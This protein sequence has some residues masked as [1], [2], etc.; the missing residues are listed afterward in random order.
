MRRAALA[1][2]LSLGSGALA[3]HAL[4]DNPQ[5]RTSAHDQTLAR[6]AV[7]QLSDFTAGSGWSGGPMSPS[8]SMSTK[9]SFDP[10]QS[11]L[12][13]TGEA[14]SSFKY[15]VPLLAVYSSATVYRTEDMARLSW[16]RAQPGLL[17]FLRCIV[18]ASLPSTAAGISVQPMSFPRLGSFGGGYRTTFDIAAGTAK[19]G[20][21]IDVDIV[22]TGRTILSLIQFAPAA[23]GDI[24]KSGEIRLAGAMAARANALAA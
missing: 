5:I 12:V 11:D 6:H 20:L 16:Q 24:V 1:A 14:A 18:H 4:A 3:A 17:G 10:R 8:D 7:V 19:V 21:V 2:L 15:K 9:C 23:V 13:Q 22:V